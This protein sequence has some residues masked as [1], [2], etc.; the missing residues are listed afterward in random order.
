MWCGCERPPVPSL[1]SPSA[2]G[3]CKHHVDERGV[4]L[5]AWKM[6][7]EDGAAGNHLDGFYCRRAAKR[8]GMGRIS[9]R[10]DSELIGYQ[11]VHTDATPRRWKPVR[12]HST[13]IRR[14][15]AYGFSG[16]CR[17]RNAILASHFGFGGIGIPVFLSR[18]RKPPANPRVGA[19]VGL[20]S[21]SGVGRP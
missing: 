5:W 4:W 7:G 11:R 17:N 3:F 9:K 1:P 10:H 8:V 6:A 18:K 19:N 14:R 21:F 20:S 13:A 16:G 15:G 2:R 12:L